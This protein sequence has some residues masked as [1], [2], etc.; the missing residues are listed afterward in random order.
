MQ[1]AWVSVSEH[2]SRVPRAVRTIVQAARRMVA[3]IGTYP[4]Y[5]TLFFFRGRE[6]D[7]GSGLLEGGGKELRFIR[8]RSPADAGRPPVKRLVRKA[9]TLRGTRRGGKPQVS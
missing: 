4:R 6:L 2:L 3:A 1:H 7:D 9:F 8:L 5:A